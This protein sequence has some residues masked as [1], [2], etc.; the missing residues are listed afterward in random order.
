MDGSAEVAFGKLAAQK[1]S[2]EDVRA[3]GQHMVTD[4]SEINSSL[5]AAADAQGI[6]LPNK[7]SPED[8]ALSARL[9]ALSGE[10]FDREYLKAMQDAHHRDLREFRVEL[11]STAD[12]E[13]HDAV[14][15]GVILIHEHMT[16]VD[17]MARARGIEPPARQSSPS[18]DTS[19]SLPPQP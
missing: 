4:H 3:L 17:R 10:E 1:G 12:P 5:K 13:L 9:G 19:A 16:S 15:K 2:T 7:L 18:S 14:R 8:Q 6:M 11:S